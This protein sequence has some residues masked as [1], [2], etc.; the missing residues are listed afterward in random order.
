MKVSQAEAQWQELQCAELLAVVSA[1]RRR[2]GC[3]RSCVPVLV[4]CSGLRVNSCWRQEAL[5]LWRGVL[6]CVHLMLCIC[7][8]LFGRF[9][10][11]SGGLLCPA[12]DEI[13]L[14]LC[15]GLQLVPRLSM[16]ESV[17]R[18]GVFWLLYEER[19]VELVYTS[20]RTEPV[21]R[22]RLAQEG[23]GARD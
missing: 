15:V 1:L 11:G 5:V 16:A 22:D 14:V 19:W 6:V 7:S 9:S 2:L 3:Y 18:Q 10:T 17:L 4:G 20:G 12:H 23:L 13:A 21:C 8:G